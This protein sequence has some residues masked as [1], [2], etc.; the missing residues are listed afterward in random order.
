MN[1]DLLTLLSSFDILHWL[2]I[3]FRF[4]YILPRMTSKALPL[5]P[6]FLLLSAVLPT[7]Q[8]RAPQLL[9]A[10]SC[11]SVLN[12][13]GKTFFPPLLYLV[14]SYPSESDQVS[15]SESFTVSYLVLTLYLIIV[16]HISL[17]VIISCPVLPC[18]T[19]VSSLL[20]S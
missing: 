5:Q 9:C 7:C 6:H 2:L 19:V 1:A 16:S 13:P 18:H 10:V 12:V 8:N 17:I 11:I 15:L 4:E 14:N 20:T 3:A